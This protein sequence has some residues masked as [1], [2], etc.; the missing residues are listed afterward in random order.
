MSSIDNSLEGGGSA[1]ASGKKGVIQLSDGN[2]NLT[3]NKELKSDPAT[4]TI[5][6]TG[7]TTTG[8]VFAATISTSNLVA[9]TVTELT[10][11]GD[12]SITGNAVVDGTINTNNLSVTDD[13][14]ITGNLSVS[15]GVVTIT[16]TSTESFALNV[17]NAGTGPAI[18]ANQ[19][20]LQPVVDFQDE[21]DSVFFI[22]GGEGS[23][24]SAYV[25]IGT[26][27]PNKKLDVVGEIRG[28][29][30]TATGTLS[31]GGS[32][33]GP[34]LTVSGQVRGATISSTG[35]V[36]ATGNVVATGSLTGASA[37]VS[38]QVQGATILSTGS[39][40]GASATVSGQ[41]QGATIL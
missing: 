4:G 11:V 28:T 34:S 20:G 14:L 35:N 22:S 5:T 23:H 27:T 6:T 19:T 13:V 9:D 32:L 1:S 38:G 25:G 36:N 12:A 29:N 30:L 7:L 40:T 10:V 39:L 21:G 41:V 8:T 16:S 3:S 26:T 15:G 17:Q 33:T 18:V 24:P 31:V 2:F 37:T